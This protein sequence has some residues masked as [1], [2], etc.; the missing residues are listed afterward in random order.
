M[1]ICICFAAYTVYKEL[2]RW[3][4]INKLELS[5]EK[6]INEIKEIRQLKYML[7]KSKKIKT[8]ILNP[9]QKQI[10]LLKLKI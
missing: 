8:K 2:E 9:T 10:Q 7:P 6:A 1:D 4:K 3:L 5:P